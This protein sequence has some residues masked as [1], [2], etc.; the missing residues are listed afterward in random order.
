M[1][2]IILI[3]VLVI[4][5]SL[6]LIGRNKANQSLESEHIDPTNKPVI[7][8][9][10]DSLMDNSLQQ[11]IQEGRAPAL[12]FLME[13]GHYYPDFVSSYPTMSVSID[14]TLLTGKYPDE[15]R[16]PGLVWYN[17]A[18]TR[19]INYGT[20]KEEIFKLGIKQVIEDQLFHLNHK[21]LSKQ[22]KT[23]HEELA[24]SGL[25]TGSINALVYRGNEPKTINLSETLANVDLMPKS[26]DIMTPTIFSYG[27]FAQY[28][29]ENKKNTQLWERYGFN[30]P[31]VTEELKSI[32]KN[33]KLPALTLAY[34][35][36]LDQAVHKDGPQNHMEAIEK[37]DQYLQ[38]VL[39]SYRSWEEA[40]K[41]NVWMVMGDSG[42]AP[43][44]GD[45]GESL[46]SLHS[47]LDAYNIHKTSEPMKDDDQIVLALNERMVY[48]YS[49][50]KSVKLHDIAT[51]L[52]EDDRINFIAWKS[53]EGVQVVNSDKEGNLLFRPNGPLTDPYG[54][55]WTVEGE[56]SIL[57]LKQNN[58][59]L[60]YGIYPD[61]LA[62]LHSALHSHKGTFL[63]AD[64]KPG[65][66]FIGEGTPTH[67]GGGSHGSLHEDD[68]LVPLIVTGTDTKPNN[69]R[70]KDMKPWIEQ[71][72]LGNNQ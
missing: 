4:A 72:I 27:A 58:N 20:A 62:R 51:T 35:A 18:E 42:Q 25:Q 32:I 10:V 12:K 31:F 46:I 1:I 70:L 33:D 57:D 44:K 60:E 13:N 52:Q 63:I 69:F 7:L 45:K 29:P 11:A 23:I 59:Q 68:S 43:V 56:L 19:L 55:S 66:E 48:I 24:N 71:L 65:Y 40:L 61:A 17:K 49:V 21:H 9:I 37:V 34:Y 26:V 8:L 14:S 54:Q 5:L 22:T 2:Y 36:D 50:D 30:D 6:F 47:L 67:P 3:V 53:N 64:A 15:H 41:N 39:D 28:S 16:I 38:E